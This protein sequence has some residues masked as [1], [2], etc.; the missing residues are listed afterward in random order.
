MSEY[1]IIK[2]CRSVRIA[3]FLSVFSYFASIWPYI[4]NNW[5]DQRF[6]KKLWCVGLF[7]LDSCFIFSVSVE[8]TCISL[9][10]I[11][12]LYSEM[13]GEKIPWNRWKNS[14][15]ISYILRVHNG[16]SFL[17]VVSVSFYDWNY[18]I[19]RNIQS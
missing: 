3:E 6:K 13:K 15:R 18:A 11:Y 1:Q 7:S 5:T 2:A 9:W 10:R 8:T 14:K 16:S 19:K 12:F 17:W 4:Q